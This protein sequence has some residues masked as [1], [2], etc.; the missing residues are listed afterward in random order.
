MAFGL[1]LVAQEQRY[2]IGFPGD[3]LEAFAEAIVAVLGFGDFDVVL[4]HRRTHEDQ[5][6]VPFVEGLVEAGGEDAGLEAGG[7]EHALLG[8]GDAL[9]GEEFLGVD[10]LVDGHGVVAEVSDFVDVFEADDGEGGGGEAVFTGVLGGADLA[11]GGAR[12]GGTS[13]IGAVG[14]ELL[15]R[16]G[17]GFRARHEFGSVK[18]S[19]LRCSMGRGWSLK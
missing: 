11:F 1:G 4:A 15:V 13:G 9:D 5:G 2:S 19:D 16:D 14:G 3:A 8:E 12:A 10:R 6:P 17:L 7:A 18:T